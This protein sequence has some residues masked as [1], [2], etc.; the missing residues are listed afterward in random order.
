M[1]SA[2]LHNCISFVGRF[3]MCFFI[4]WK[5]TMLTFTIMH[6]YHCNLLKVCLWFKLCTL[7]TPSWKIN[8][9]YGTILRWI[10]FPIGINQMINYKCFLMEF[11]QMVPRTLKLQMLCTTCWGQFCLRLQSY[12]KHPHSVG[13]LRGRHKAWT[14]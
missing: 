8:L 11:E 12:W 6:N 3:V 14:F 10:F 13:F 7:C 1:L 4:S 2:L 9:F 5:L